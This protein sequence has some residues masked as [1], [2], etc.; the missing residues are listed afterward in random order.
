MAKVPKGTK[1]IQVKNEMGKCKYKPLDEVTDKDEIQVNKEGVPVSMKGNPGRPKTV[2]MEPVNRVAAAV[3]QLK[4]D[5]M[6][7]DPVLKIAREKPEDPDVLHQII[8]A[9][10]EEA[11]SIGF[12]RTRAEQNGEKTSELSVRRIGALK[13][14]AD[15]WLKRKDQI[16]SRGIDMNSPAFR[17]LLKFIME[18]FQESMSSS[19]ARPEMVETVFA[20]LA[21]M[22][23]DEWEAEARNRM[24][25][26]V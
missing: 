18:T 19:G 26:V 6:L 22:M 20:K 9:L 1:Y 21:K 11:A 12:E 8:M 3:I 25:H 16:S 17:V 2:V 24:K 4:S 10:G 5:A 23:G 13:A 14:I 7:N 15:T